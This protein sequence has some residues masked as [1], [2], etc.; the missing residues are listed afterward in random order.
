MIQNNKKESFIGETIMQQ[1]RCEDCGQ[2]YPDQGF[3]HRCVNC[4]GMF[5]YDAPFTI[6]QTD[7]NH[8]ETSLWQY[9]HAFGL[10]NE[11]D[12]VSLGEGKTPLLCKTINGQ[13]MGFKMESNN[14]TGSYKDRGTTI[15][16]TE[17]K[18]RGIPFAIEDSSGNAGA[19]FATYCTW[20][21]L[22][23]KM[24]V[25]ESASGAKLNQIKRSNAILQ[26]VPGERKNA[27]NAV[28]QAIAS[29]GAVY[30]SHALQP[31]ILPGIAT[32]AYELVEELQQCPGTILAPVGHGGL[33]LGIMRGFDALYQQKII[34]HT[35]LLIGVQAMGYHPF[36]SLFHPEYSVPNE[37]T[38]ESLADGV[39]IHE[40][41]RFRQ[42]KKMTDTMKCDFIA[43]TNDELRVAV[44]E[45]WK[46]GLYI[47]ST[48]ALV[49]A[50]YRKITKKLPEPIIFI[51]TGSGLKY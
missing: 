47:E 37:L 7:L 25:P 22:Q 23:G 8:K 36:V 16:A 24:F 3:P 43:C 10:S 15:L 45:L 42:I 30:A 51:L 12:P 9:R 50:A 31:F 14:P 32:I 17:L 49:W 46:M 29:E 27:T 1:I 48:S 40:P 19:S 4:G 33:F 2:P 35:P 28:M 41:S 13:S 6:H 34:Q 39:R 44:N 38:E 18:A 21:G 20:A 5:D 26:T 11:C